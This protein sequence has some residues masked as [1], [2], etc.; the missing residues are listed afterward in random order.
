[1]TPEHP[2][3]PPPD[4]FA[5]SAE[6]VAPDLVGA[7]VVSRVGGATTSGRIVET[8]AYLGHRDPASHGYRYRRHAGNASLYAP[9]GTWYVYRSYGIHWCANLVC[10]N[11]AGDGSAVLIRALEPLAGL[12]AMRRRRGARTDVALCSGPGKLTQAMGI[13][14]ALDGKSMANAPVT[15][16][17]DQTMQ[18]ARVVVTPRIGITK[19]A[20]WPLRFA[21]EGS[22]WVSRPTSARRA[23]PPAIR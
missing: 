16:L 7:V 13:T 15:V 22:P 10:G 18:P 17:L 21:A 5:R 8:E 20:D 12:P 1:M 4:F 3:L 19:A 2:V 14:R 9:P 6:I 23:S 11:E